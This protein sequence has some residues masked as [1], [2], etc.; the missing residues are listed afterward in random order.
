MDEGTNL[1]PDRE[2]TLMT[3]ARLRGD[4]RPGTPLLTV[5]WSTGRAPAGWLLEQAGRRV[6]V[7]FADA[8]LGPGDM[9]AEA[10]R[11]PSRIASVR[12][13]TLHREP[14]TALEFRG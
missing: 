6:L 3:T 2:E 12:H 11:P 13:A 7:L 14:V 10:G 4:G 9:V 1:S 5:E 8:P